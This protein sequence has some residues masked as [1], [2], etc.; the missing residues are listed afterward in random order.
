MYN[1][2]QNFTK[3]VNLPD[4]K[5]P[6]TGLTSM[7]EKCA[8]LLASGIRITDVAKQIGASRGAIYRWLNLDAFQCFYNLMKQDVKNYVEGSV[9]ELHGLALDGIKAGLS[10]QNEAIRLK[11]SMWVIEK[12]NQMQVGATDVR[13]VLKVKT[14]ES[15][16]WGAEDRYRKALDVAGID[17]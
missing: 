7:Q 8:V 2:K 15:E 12:I 6:D 1:M 14:S 16:E 13:Q 10:S 9:L 5:S 3:S 17:A 11:T 4:V